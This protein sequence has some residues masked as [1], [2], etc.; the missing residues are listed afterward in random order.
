[1]MPLQ[2]LHASRR[3][4][5]CA[6]ATDN[7]DAIRFMTARTSP[8]GLG[9]RSVCVAVTGDVRRGRF[10]AHPAFAGLMPAIRE[11]RMPPTVALRTV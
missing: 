7:S 8:S 4:I 9:F 3:W 1:M 11:F 10:R 6:T 5:A 2:P